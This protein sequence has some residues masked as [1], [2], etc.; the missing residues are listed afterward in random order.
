[1]ALPNDYIY[2]AKSVQD[3]LDYLLPSAPHW[4]LA[5][6]GDLAYRGQASSIWCLVPRAFRNGQLVAYEP[7]APTASP[8]RVVIQAR[9]EFRAMQQFVKVADTSGLQITD[10]GGRMLLQEEPRYIF[11]DPN[12]EYRW[13]Q[14]DV[15]ETLALVQHHGIPTR[16]LDFTEDPLV[17]AYFAASSAWDP[18]KRRRI[19][20]RERRYL[21]VWVIDLRFIRAIEKIGGRYPE[22]VGE[23]RVPRANNSYLHA[24]FGF[25]LI[26]RGSNDV[27]GRGDLLSINKA[28]AD[29]ARFWHNGNRLAGKGIKQTWFDE[30]PVRQVRLATN[31][32]GDLLRELENRGITKVSLM[33]SLDRVVESLEF[34]RSIPHLNS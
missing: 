29:R 28:V 2:T 6:R 25:F 17:G 31:L 3:F 8:T 15:L 34:Q 16:L 24:Q 23:V 11:N 33:P 19:R 18:L 20:G 30:F 22:R 5:K 7:D 26:D 32:T 12:W 13:P 14:E 27:M 21:S 1:M 4:L 10:V 9:A